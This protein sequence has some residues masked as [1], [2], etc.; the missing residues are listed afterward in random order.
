M[1]F[2]FFMMYKTDNP[3]GH[4]ITLRVCANPD[5]GTT[6]TVQTG[7]QKA[8]SSPAVHIEHAGGTPTGYCS[9]RCL[10]GA[11]GWDLDGLKSWY[12]DLGMDYDQ[13]FPPGYLAP[14][15]TVN[16]HNFTLITTKGGDK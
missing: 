3:G 10:F 12:L 4:P 16:G 7:G 6:Y 13:I 1:F 9:S 2:C 11:K 14:S 5:C 15:R 8:G